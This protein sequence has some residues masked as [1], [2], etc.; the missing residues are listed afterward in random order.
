VHRPDPACL[1]KKVLALDLDQTLI[2]SRRSAGEVDELVCVE[3]KDEKPLSHMTVAAYEVL[4]DLQQRHHVVPV[5]TRTAEQYRRV[6]LPHHVK[7]AVTCNGGVLLHKG[8]RDAEWAE[9]VARDLTTVAPASE[10]AKLFQRVEDEPWVNSWRQVEDLFVYLVAASRKQ[11]P[12][13]WASTAQAWCEEHGWTLSVQGR[14]AYAV[15]QVLSKGAAAL[16]IAE[17]LGGELLA[18][19]DS[20]LDRDLLE[21]A[22]YAVRPAHG[23][24]H[25]L[26]YEGAHVT[27]RSGALGGEDLLQMLRR[28]A[29]RDVD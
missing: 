5:T 12:A 29:D 22:A 6:H 19:G 2:Y 14:K 15:P 8:K 17:Q 21:A 24:L 9:R 25:L 7:W 23:E 11:L 10:A 16:R 1:V 13:Q 28:H 3:Q 4:A 20:L 26:G 18:A 27:E